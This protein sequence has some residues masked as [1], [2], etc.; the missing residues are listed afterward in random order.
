[1]PG[2]YRYLSGGSAVD[3]PLTLALLPA[4]HASFPLAGW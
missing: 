2:G 3:H 1:L 4:L